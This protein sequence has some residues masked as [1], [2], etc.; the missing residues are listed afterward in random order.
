MGW[1]T[2]AAV[3]VAAARCVQRLDGQL[4]GVDA[5]H[6]NS[7]RNQGPQ[8]AD[9]AICQITFICIGPRLISTSMAQGH[10]S[11]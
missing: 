7:S 4:Q 2:S 8:S 6:L 5:D 9:A 11:S 10:F 3:G 1:R